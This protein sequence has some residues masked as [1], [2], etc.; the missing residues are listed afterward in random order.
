LADSQKPASRGL[1]LDDERSRSRNAGDQLRERSDRFLAAHRLLDQPHDHHQYSAA[2]PSGGYLTNDRANIK[3]SRPSARS[4]CSATQQRT[5]YL[6]PDAAS[7][8]SGDRI[9]DGAEVVLLQQRAGDVAADATGYKLDNQT[10]D[11]TPHFDFLPRL[12]FR[13][14]RRTA[15]LS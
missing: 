12:R 13:K 4:R 3:A 2:D 7:D 8:N 1:A 9:A 5:D 15:R 10:D 14:N 6:S 11:A